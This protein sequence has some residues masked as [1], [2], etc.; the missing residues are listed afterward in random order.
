MNDSI[1]CTLDKG[2]GEKWL[3]ALV[4]RSPTST[5][6]NN[7]KLLENIKW[8]SREHKPTHYKLFG[9]F[10]FP[11]INWESGTCSD[12]EE[13]MPSKFLDTINDLFLYQHVQGSTRFRGNQHSR[14]DLIF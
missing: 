9:D 11:N 13:S 10:N 7:M 1:W 3:I 4:Y 2:Q 8:A 5:L 12:P 6:E 14:L